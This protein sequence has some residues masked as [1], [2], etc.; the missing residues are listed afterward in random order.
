MKTYYPYDVDSTVAIEGEEHRVIGGQIRLDHIPKEGT[1]EVR[2][3]VEGVDASNLT[4]NQFYC[5]Y[6]KDTLYREANRI[7]YF[8]KGRS[9]QNVYCSY[10]AIGSPVTADDMNEIRDFMA[11]SDSKFDKQAVAF[12]NLNTK[13][14]ALEEN[15]KVYLR[16]HNTRS[17]THMDIRD[18]I[19]E[20]KQENSAQHN[21][22]RSDF[23]SALNTH[24][25]NANAHEPIRNSI[26]AVQ[27]NLNDF[28]QTVPNTIASLNKSIDR[29]DKTLVGYENRLRLVENQVVELNQRVRSN[30][31][32]IDALEELTHENRHG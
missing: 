24:N 9:G 12:S 20:F 31:H 3:F 1:L 7:V 10:I 5:N 18:N 21:Q 8:Y 22:I 14:N 17:D 25:L 29:L 26:S 30:Q 11:A 19:S 28:K 16:E 27:N 23:N 6:R 15:T 4:A 32:R 2:G 13:F